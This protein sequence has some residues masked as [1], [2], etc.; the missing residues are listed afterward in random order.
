MKPYLDLLRKVRHQG[1]PRG[2]RTGVG[3]LSLFGER[4][5]IDLAYAPVLTTKEIKLKPLLTE[6]AWFLRGETTTDYLHSHAVKLWDPWADADGSVGPIYGYQWRHW[7]GDQLRTIVDEIANNPMS[8]RLVVSAWNVADLPSM[9]LP[10]CPISFQFYVDTDAGLSCHVYQ[11][12]A[13]AFLGLPFDLAQYGILTQLIAQEVGLFPD[14]L[15]FSFGDLHIYNNHLEQ[16]D[17]Q[18]TRAPHPR[19]EIWIS[20]GTTIDNFYPEAVELINYDHDPA[21]FGK[22]AV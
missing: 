3:T 16:V 2:D 18:L 22:V 15:I 21:I 5:E 8:R 9:A 20:E 4:L 13:D 12:S 10:P 1:H 7:G 17:L 11:R 19:P 14:R 6:L